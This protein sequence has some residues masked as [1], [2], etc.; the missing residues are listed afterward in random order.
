MDYTYSNYKGRYVNS[1][2]E[3]LEATRNNYFNLAYDPK[4]RK[5][6]VEEIEKIIDFYNATDLYAF[7]H[8]LYDMGTNS[9]LSRCYCILDMIVSWDHAPAK[10]LLGTMYFYGSYV[11]KDYDKFFKLVSESA[12]DN[13]ILAKN[14]LD[15]SRP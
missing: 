12:N 5:K 11:E 2:R 13:F 10:Q 3:Y 15:L 14:S 6:M 9:S 1:A 4:Q 7:A 8:L